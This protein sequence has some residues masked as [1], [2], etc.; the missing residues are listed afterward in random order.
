MSHAVEGDVFTQSALQATGEGNPLGWAAYHL[1]DVI[2]G[3]FH[4]GLAA[5][6]CCV[7]HC[8][9]GH[10]AIAEGIEG[11]T[12]NICCSQPLMCNSRGLS[13]RQA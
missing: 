11:I 8:S 2:F 5:A 1:G 3:A 4:A 12:S 10:G 9:A 6:L 13:G 7:L